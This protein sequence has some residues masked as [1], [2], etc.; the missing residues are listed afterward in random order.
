MESRGQKGISGDSV[1]GDGYDRKQGG[2][3]G[4]VFRTSIVLFT[5]P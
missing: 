3:M 2:G 5:A 4:G 1:G